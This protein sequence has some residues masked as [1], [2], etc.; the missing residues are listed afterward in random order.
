MNEGANVALR[1]SIAAFWGGV[2]L[3]GVFR[4]FLAVGPFLRDVA[5]FLWTGVAAPVLGW[6][7]GVLIGLPWLPIVVSG[8]IAVAT[9]WIGVGIIMV[10]QR[11]AEKRLQHDLE[12][13]S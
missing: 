7:W 10:I 13:D 4:L 12:G 3:Y 6:V 9:L 2:V 1:F 8:L 11:Q 5:E